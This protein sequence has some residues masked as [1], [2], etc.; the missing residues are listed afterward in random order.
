MADPGD[1]LDECWLVVFVGDVLQVGSTIQGC[2]E[3]GASVAV[4]SGELAAA[5]ITQIEED[6]PTRIE[7]YDSGATRH[8]SPY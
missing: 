4:A 1:E 2:D 8:I 6:R 3:V 5:A 7:L